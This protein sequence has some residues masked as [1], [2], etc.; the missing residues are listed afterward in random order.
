MP[1]W[2]N[3]MSTGP[4]I[5]SRST[6]SSDRIC[7]RNGLFDGQALEGRHEVVGAAVPVE[8]RRPDAGRRASTAENTCLNIGY[9]DPYCLSRSAMS[10]VAKR[11][12][13]RL[14]RSTRLGEYR[15]CSS[16]RDLG[17]QPG[18][19]RREQDGVVVAQ[20]VDGARA[21]AGHEAHQA[22]FAADPRRP[23]ELVVAE[24][25]AAERRQVVAAHLRAHHFLDHDPHLLVEVEQAALGAVLDGVGA[26]GAR[27]HLGDGVADGRQPVPL[28]AAV[29]QEQA[30]VLARE[31]RPDPVFQQAGAADDERLVAD[32]VEGHGEALQDLLGQLRVLERLDDVRVF[33][34]DLLDLE[35]LPVVD[36]L[37]VVVVEEG[38][39]AVRRDVPRLRHPERPEGVGVLLRAAHDVVGE[40]QAGALAA[41]LA[42]RAR[43]RDDVLHDVAEVVDVQVVLRGVDVLE[44]VGEEAAHQRHAQADLHRSRELLV[45]EA[46]LL[47][48]LEG[49]GDLG[50]RRALVLDR[51]D[52][53][54]ALVVLHPLLD[55]VDDLVVGEVVGGDAEGRVRH[56]H[57]RRRGSARSSG[58]FSSR[59]LPFPL[60]GAEVLEQ[61]LGLVD[62]APDQVVDH[63]PRDARQQVRV[64]AAQELDDDAPVAA[65]V[66]GRPARWRHLPVPRHAAQAAPG[67]ELAQAQAM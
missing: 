46:H 42:A 31:G 48:A 51:L 13:S 65:L 20:A 59:D 4:P 6:R 30:L 11:L 23:A 53:E 45:A 60:V 22:V 64:G 44:V 15:S 8:A 29:R 63:P 62:A 17:A 34:P 57:Q 49:V 56:P 12:A 25:H 27:V 24:R 1:S 16:G 54:P 50:E 43:R 7:A 58:R 10:T 33:L 40:Q 9:F 36:V 66:A 32:V 21:E 55:D 41:Q 26:E 38:E 47:E 61:V 5:F 3:S 28:A 19:A 39:E 14:M 37:Q 2:A 18:L 35:V 52:E 67:E